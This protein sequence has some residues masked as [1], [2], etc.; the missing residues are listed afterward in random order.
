M[1]IYSRLSI[2][3]EDR[4]VRKIQK[5]Y[6]GTRNYRN[7]SESQLASDICTSIYLSGIGSNV[8]GIYPLYNPNGELNGYYVIIDIYTYSRN[9]NYIKQIADRAILRFGNFYPL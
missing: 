1:K 9:T 7:S 2:N 3:I 8:T 4:R 5:R 6:Y